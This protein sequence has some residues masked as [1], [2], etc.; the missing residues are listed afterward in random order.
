MTYDSSK[1][2]VTYEV[3]DYKNT[4]VT[5]TVLDDASDSDSDTLSIPFVWSPSNERA[6]ASK[7][8]IS[9]TQDSGWM[10]TN[11]F[12]YTVTDGDLSTATVTVQVYNR[13]PVAGNDSARKSKNTS[14]TVSVLGD[15]S[16]PDGD[17]LSIS[18]VGT[19]GK[20]TAS[21]SGGES[22]YTPPDSWTGM[23]SLVG[24]EVLNRTTTARATRRSGHGRSTST[25][26]G[27]GTPLSGESRCSQRPRGAATLHWGSRRATP[28]GEAATTSTLG[29]TVWMRNRAAYVSAL[30]PRTARPIWPE[31]STATGQG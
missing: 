3:D 16:D 4:P 17:S 14:V 1:G 10:G 25:P 24:Y 9:Y 6:S 11:S 7:R 13:A 30:T 8:S 2:K 22:T 31:R 28:T 15:D 23:T 19:P 18:S 12:S 27:H 26:V 20:G 21:E 29:T 5:V